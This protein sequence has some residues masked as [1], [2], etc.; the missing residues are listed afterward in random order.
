MLRPKIIKLL[1][2]NIGAKLLDIGLSNNLL[3]MTPKVQ[4]TKANI[5]SGNYIKQKSSA[6]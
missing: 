1:E 3:D 4:E 2:G 5:I 6:Q